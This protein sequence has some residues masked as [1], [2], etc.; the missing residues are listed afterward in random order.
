MRY[1]IFNNY[2]IEYTLLRKKVKNIN[3]RI[4]PDCTVQVS[5]GA[6]VSITDIEAFILK[7]GGRIIAALEKFSD[8]Q[9]NEIQFLSGEKAFL[10][11]K[12]FTLEI[13]ESNKNEYQIENEKLILFV[14]NSNDFENRKCVYDALK[15]DCAQKIFPDIFKEIY[16]NFRNVCKSIPELRIR[17]MKTQWG[18]CRPNKNI[19]TLNLRLAEYDINVIRFVLCHEFCHFIHP[20]HS[21]AFYDELEKVMPD[22]RKYDLILKNR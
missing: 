9:K 8:K 13:A 22:W 19:I 14:K 18:N 10:L 21:N 5:A 7:N 11:G 16:P 20:N 3:L 4:K 6:F 17:N 15:R 2:R 1:V 12:E